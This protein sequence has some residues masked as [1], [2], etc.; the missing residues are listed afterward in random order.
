LFKPTGSD[1]FIEN[2]MNERKVALVLS[3]CF[4]KNYKQ[5]ALSIVSFS[6]VDIL[7]EV[8]ILKMNRKNHNNVL[9]PQT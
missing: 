9:I 6:I 1:V 4:Q 3:F 2:G 5:T 8:Y 7:A